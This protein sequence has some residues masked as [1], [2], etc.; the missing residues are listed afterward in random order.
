[1]QDGL[2]RV[3]YRAKRLSWGRYNT[4]MKLI[5]NSLQ[6]DPS[7]A[8]KFRL[9][10]LDHYYAHGWK[11]AVHAFGVKK[12]TLYDWKKRYEESGK[13]IVS[14]V[15][16][17]TRPKRLRQMETNTQLL[18]C[19]RSLREQYGNLSKYKIK[20]ILAEY[21]KT[22]GLEG[23][24]TSK[25]GEIIKRRRYTFAG[26]NKK[27]QIHRVK[28]LTARVKYAPKEK[29]PGYIEMDSITLYVL[30]KRYYFITAID[31]VT[32]FAWVSQ[33]S[34]LTSKAAAQAFQEFS[35]NYPHAIRTVQTDNGHEFLGDFHCTL[36]TAHIPHNFIYPR[37]PRINGVIE[38]FNRSFQE[39]FVE[40]SEELGYD[41]DT[42]S[43]KLTNYLVWYNTKRPHHALGLSTPSAFLQ[44]YY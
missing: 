41:P 27:K 24:G 23:Y 10:V 32:K 25:I 20:P 16:T 4:L 44:Q 7:D 3:R 8:G 43:A 11:S 17:S 18:L 19:I 26:V 2:N 37:S 14:L 34:S 15:P 9:H 13:K 36:E 39:E 29:T 5:T 22:Q 28:P 1:M 38:R 6:F 40:R 35:Q 21:A 33:A 12:S 30:S 42:F 31:I